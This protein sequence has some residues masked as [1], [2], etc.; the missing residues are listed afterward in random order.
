MSNVFIVMKRI[1]WDADDI[2]KVCA[3]RDIA[4]NIVDAYMR[5]NG[6]LP[7]DES[8]YIWEEEVLG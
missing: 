6:P 1:E 2:I 3:S 5:L 7:A 4:E 8:L